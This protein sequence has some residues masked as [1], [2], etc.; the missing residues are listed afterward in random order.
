MATELLAHEIQLIMT[1]PKAIELFIFIL[2]IILLYRRLVSKPPEQRYI[3]NKL[4][5]LAFLLW[6]IYMIC[7]MILYNLAALP[8]INYVGDIAKV[9]N[10]TGYPVE[11]PDVLISQILRDIAMTCGFLMCYFYLAA[12]AVIK[13]GEEYTKQK[14]F[15]NV[16]FNLICALLIIILV[17]GDQIGVYK[18]GNSVW[19]E[20]K[21][22]SAEGA[23]SLLIIIVVLLISSIMF[24]RTIMAMGQEDPAVKRRSLL[25]GSGILTMALGGIYWMVYGIIRSQPGVQIDL[26]IQIPIAFLG[27]IIWTICPILIYLGL[28]DKK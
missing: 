14:I 27:H 4:F 26:S 21:W 7:D 17:A 1:I 6:A 2:M 3:L 18:V 5:I 9:D 28:R 11:Y 10:I 16:I 24:F 25:I 22:G 13:N 15:K 20:E 12:A 19:V 8:F 23:L